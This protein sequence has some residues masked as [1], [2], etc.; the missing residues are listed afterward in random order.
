MNNQDLHKRFAELSTPLIADACLRVGLPL[1]IAPAGIHPIAVGMKL[2]GRA[3]PIRHY[4]SVDIFLEAIADSQ[5]GDVLVLITTDARTKAASVIYLFWRLRQEVS[6]ES[7]CGGC[8]ATQR[9]CIKSAFL[10]SVMARFLLDQRAWI[11]ATLR[12]SHRRVLEIFKLQI[13]MWSLPMT[14]ARCS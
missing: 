2:A 14:T 11:H 10:F 5:P 13:K 4:G 9:N 1:R 8:I 12:R 7:C 3:R 6:R